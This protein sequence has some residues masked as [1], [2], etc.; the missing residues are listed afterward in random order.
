VFI[1]WAIP[2]EELPGLKQVC[3]EEKPELFFSGFV[4]I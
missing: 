2:A 1:S 3:P 4:E